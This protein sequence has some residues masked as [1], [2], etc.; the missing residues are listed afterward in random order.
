MITVAL[1]HWS[2]NLTFGIRGGCEFS[3][4]APRYR[5]QHP[6]ELRIFSPVIVIAEATK[7][8]PKIASDP[9]RLL[10]NHGF[11]AEWLLARIQRY[12][13]FLEQDP[14]FRI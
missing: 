2:F 8:H 4:V 12:S 11:S 6:G 10:K 9:S 5:I 7:K 13:N 3:E 14:L 1:G